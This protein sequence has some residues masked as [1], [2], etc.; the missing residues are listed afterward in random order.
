MLVRGTDLGADTTT[1]D[2]TL[3][4]LGTFPQLYLHVDIDVL[5]P[6]EAPGVDY[7]AAGGLQAP[8]LK[9][10]VRTVAGLG[11]VRALAL[12]AV[13]PEKDIDGRTVAA[14]LDVIEAAIDKVQSAEL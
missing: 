5:D 3:H 14:A 10:A 12:T 11:N 7:P 2:R 6:V 13:N 1:L 4:A 8:Q 9:E